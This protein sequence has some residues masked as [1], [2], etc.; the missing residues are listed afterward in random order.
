[1]LS[2]S[3]TIPATVPQRSELP[4]GLMNYS[5]LLGRKYCCFMVFSITSSS[6]NNNYRPAET[7]AEVRYESQIIMFKTNVLECDIRTD[8][9]Q[10]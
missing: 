3:V 8:V 1:M 5:V 2:F 6:R 4:E 9:L 10:L 7:K